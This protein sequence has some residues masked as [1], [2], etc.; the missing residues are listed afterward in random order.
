M[1]RLRDVPWCLIVLALIGS[2]PVL[3][4]P[5]SLTGFVQQDFNKATSPG[6]S[7]PATT[8]GK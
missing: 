7:T 3:A 8:G 4:D 2:R 1:V 5:I 6:T